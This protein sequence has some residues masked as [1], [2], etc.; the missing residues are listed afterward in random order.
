MNNNELTLVTGLCYLSLWVLPLASPCERTAYI[1][2]TQLTTILRTIT[3]TKL[4]AQADF[5]THSCYT[6]TYSQSYSYHYS[7]TTIPT[8]T[9]KCTKLMDYTTIKKRNTTTSVDIG[10]K[11]RTTLYHQGTESSMVAGIHHPEWST[12][13]TTIPYC[14]VHSFSAHRHYLFHNRSLHIPRIILPDRE[15]HQ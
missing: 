9:T 12:V 11:K 8:P 13:S 2:P 3:C 7:T 15:C 5:R 10:A 14:V 1:W 4:V 6:S